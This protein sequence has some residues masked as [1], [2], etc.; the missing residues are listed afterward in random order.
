M[1]WV[2]K[3]FNELDLNEL[4]KIL[5]IRNEVF[6]IEQNCPYHDCDNKDLDAYHIYCEIN[7]EI[8][9]Y[10]RILRKGVSYEE[11]S[12]GRVLS[13]EKFRG[14]KLSKECMKRAIS[15]IENEL[16]E[17]KIRISAQEYA[18][19]FYEKV[20]FKKVSETYLEDDIPHIEMLYE[21]Q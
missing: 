10:S 12:I 16:N 7:G 20:G 13:N 14:K 9:A 1:K 15:F 6:V 2:L 3:H 5:R 21:K 17:E 8:G 18:K 11:A 19:G 4:Y